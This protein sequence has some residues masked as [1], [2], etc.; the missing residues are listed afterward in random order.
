MPEAIPHVFVKFGL[1]IRSR[2]LMKS[3]K[4]VRATQFKAS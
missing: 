1:Q 3:F 4:A 2:G